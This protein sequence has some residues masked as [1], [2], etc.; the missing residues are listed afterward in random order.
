M[1][2]MLK[3]EYHKN[4]KFYLKSMEVVRKYNNELKMINSDEST[5]ASQP[6]TTTS[7]L[8]P[9]ASLNTIVSGSG[10]CATTNP[11][12]SK[13]KLVS[14]ETQTLAK[15]TMLVDGSSNTDHNETEV[16]GL[17]ANLLEL[18]TIRAKLF[19]IKFILEETTTTTTTS[20]EQQVQPRAVDSSMSIEVLLGTITSQVRDLKL[21]SVTKTN[22]MKTLRNQNAKI[23]V[24]FK[25][26][27]EAKLKLESLY[28]I[29]C[30]S[31]L[32]KSAQIKKLE[33]GYQIELI[34]F[35]NEFNSDLVRYL[36]TKLLRKES[37]VNENFN[38]LT[39][40]LKAID[41]MSMRSSSSGGDGGEG[42]GDAAEQN[43]SVLVA[44][45][46]GKLDCLKEPIKCLLNSNLFAP[47]EPYNNNTSNN[48]G[49]S[50]GTANNS[51]VGNNATAN[52]N[53]NNNTTTTTVAAGQTTA[54][55]NNNT[56]NSSVNNGSDG[57]VSFSNE[58]KKIPLNLIVKTSNS[59][60]INN[61]SS[62][63]NNNNPNDASSSKCLVPPVKR[64]IF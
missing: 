4:S 25:Q 31:D 56:V 40:V 10:G 50:N 43:Q 28:K 60:N 52:P 6:S 63:N 13:P 53:S 5:S 12:N 54:V 30:K 19:N 2:K 36:E 59:N 1:E 26:L 49:S 39:G 51:V 35:R 15:T 17:A 64:R 45:L 42:A 9:A 27:K 21:D 41:Q 14:I 47:T 8:K 32:N 58:C 29:K 22:E 61:N 44:N 48:T 37:L 3:E 23:V 18:N 62:N 11:N 33:I 46:K 34:K 38:L 20:G 57:G 16:P 24:D 55:N 7:N